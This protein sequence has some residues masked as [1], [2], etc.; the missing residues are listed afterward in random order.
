MPLSRACLDR[1]ATDL[2]ESTQRR[3]LCAG[4]VTVYDIRRA[5]VRL[6]G[7]SDALAAQR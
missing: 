1:L 5:P 2:I 7:F 3:V 6:A 4:A